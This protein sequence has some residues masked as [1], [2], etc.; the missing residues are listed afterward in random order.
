[1]IYCVEITAAFSTAQRRNNVL[2]ILQNYVT[3][4]Q[5]D[6]FVP[7]TVGPFEAAYKGWTN[8][9]AGTMRLRTQ[10][11]RDAV[12]ADIQGAMTGPAAPVK[13]V[14]RK[15]DAPQDTSEPDGPIAN[16]TTQTWP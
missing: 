6:A 14:A 1:M 5:A 13:G 4:F 10:A 15:W 8:A 7:S 3:Q 16:D 11:N 12:W 2:G 9:V